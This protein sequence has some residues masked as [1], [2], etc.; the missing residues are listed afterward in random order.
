MGSSSYGRITPL[1]VSAVQDIA[2]I[3]STFEQNLIAWL[4]NA[5]NGIGE[6]FAPQV[7]NFQTTNASTT[8]TQTL[9]VQTICVG[10]HPN[11][12]LSSVRHQSPT[13]RSVEPNRLRPNPKI[14]DLLQ[15]SPKFDA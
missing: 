10:D 13:R 3:S 14:R 7:G 9:N 1:I 15:D 2:N 5:Q 8:N 12:P 11:R 6:F 4:G